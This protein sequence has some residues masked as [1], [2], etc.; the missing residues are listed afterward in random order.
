MISMPTMDLSMC[1]GG[2]NMPE[3]E[4]FSIFLR[5]EEENGIAPSGKALAKMYMVWHKQRNEIK[6]A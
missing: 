1:E 3:Q 2:R 5:R 6:H 4:D